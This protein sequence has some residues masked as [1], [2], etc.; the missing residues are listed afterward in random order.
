MYRCFF[1]PPLGIE[2]TEAAAPLA[3]PTRQNCQ[4]SALSFP[5]EEG[6][7]ATPYSVHAVEDESGTYKHPY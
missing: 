5:P 7:Q 2:S 3:T 1:F 6:Q 4:V